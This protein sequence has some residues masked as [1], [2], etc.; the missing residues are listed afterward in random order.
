M[1]ELEVRPWFTMHIVFPVE[2]GGHGSANCLRG[3]ACLG[4]DARDGLT[5]GQPK[6]GALHG[7]YH[8]AP[9]PPIVVPVMN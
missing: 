7:T 8:D 4:V 6:W 5:V 3:E 9:A 1:V 2:P